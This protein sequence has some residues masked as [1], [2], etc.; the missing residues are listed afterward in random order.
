M[1]NRSRV[2]DLLLAHTLD[3]EVMA[4]PSDSKMCAMRQTANQT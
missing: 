1:G 2:S 4:H 3:A